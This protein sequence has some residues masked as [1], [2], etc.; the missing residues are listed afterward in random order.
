MLKALTLPFVILDFDLSTSKRE[1]KQ[2]GQ[3][4][5]SLTLTTFIGFRLRLF[6]LSC[7]TY[8]TKTN[9][10]NEWIEVLWNFR[11]GFL[12]FLVA[13]LIEA[14]QI[15]FRR[16]KKYVI[17]RLLDM[18]KMKPSF[19]FLAYWIIETRKRK[20]TSK[21]SGKKTTKRKVNL[22]TM[23]HKSVCNLNFHF[24]FFSVFFSLAIVF[25]HQWIHWNIYII[26]SFP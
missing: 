2:I 23:T 3:S 8:E 7:R 11:R 21:N 15:Y 17:V 14:K 5:G 18:T 9:V 24:I 4:I 20:Q 10:E 26:I 22:L 13:N 1:K 12:L 16:R 6:T 25:S 19:R